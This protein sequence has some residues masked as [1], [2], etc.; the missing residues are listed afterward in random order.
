MFLFLYTY[1][2]KAKFNPFYINCFSTAI[3]KILINLFRP[4][5]LKR[6]VGAD[7]GDGT[8]VKIACSSKAK[9]IWGTARGLA[10]QVQVLEAPAK[11]AF[12]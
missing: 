8:A 7:G 5:C 1:S 11:K 2:L 4:I 10:K 9:A 3:F 6:Y 12:I